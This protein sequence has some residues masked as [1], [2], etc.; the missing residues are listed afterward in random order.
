[1]IDPHR[2][3]PPCPPHLRVGGWNLWLLH[4]DKVYLRAP[5][6]YE[7][8]VFSLDAFQDAV[9]GWNHLA[10]GQLHNIDHVAELIADFYA[11]NF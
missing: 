8:G 9:T 5:G 4:G 2:H 11:A 7:G 6:T 3:M 10:S 1:M